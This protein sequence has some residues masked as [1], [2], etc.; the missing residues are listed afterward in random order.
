MA[1]TTR[2]YRYPGVNDAPDGPYSF[3]TGFEDID[4]DVAAVAAQ[5][6]GK[7]IAAG[8][9]SGTATVTVTTG[10]AAGALAITF[11][12]AFSAAPAVSLTKASVAGAAS[13]MR[14]LLPVVSGV[15]ATGFTA[16]LETTDGT[17]VGATFAVA[18]HW[19]AV[20]N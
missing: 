19:T 17:N 3:Q 10:T 7:I 16:N 14:R 15:T 5:V 1:T 11:P 12:A 20:K 4:A 2:G 9:Q 8:V 6:D 13:T 18:V